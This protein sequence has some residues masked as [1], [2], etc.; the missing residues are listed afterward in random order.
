MIVRTIT[1]HSGQKADDL[2]R[3]YHRPTGKRPN[4]FKKMKAISELLS[5]KE[6]QEYGEHL[7]H[8]RSI[9]KEI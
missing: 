7:N 4:R 5:K 1:H 9:S 6:R 8:L 3:K 2:L